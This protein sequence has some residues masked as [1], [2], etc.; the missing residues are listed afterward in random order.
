MNA[1]SE[2]YINRGLVERYQAE[3]GPERPMQF[4]CLKCRSQAFNLF[5]NTVT[6]ILTPSCARCETPI[7]NA[8][9]QFELK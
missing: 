4:C 1:G 9:V 6:L 2:P 8:R 7:Q 5:F 3:H